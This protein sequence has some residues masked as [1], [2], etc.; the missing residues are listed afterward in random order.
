MTSNA[1]TE[2]DY[3]SKIEDR[4]IAVFEEAVQALR[5]EFPEEEA[6]EADGGGWDEF[7]NPTHAIAKAI[8][9]N[10]VLA[11]EYEALSGAQSSRLVQPKARNTI[12]MRAFDLDR[13]E[14]RVFRLNRMGQVTVRVPAAFSA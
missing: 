14:H 8:A 10:L 2:R 1:N 11:F 12:Y 3:M 6:P 13:N 4:L 5:R 9:G 7:N